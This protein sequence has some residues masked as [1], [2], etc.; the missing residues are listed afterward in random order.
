MKEEGY[1]PLLTKS[2]WLLLKRKEKLTESQ[3]IRLKDLVQYNLRS[4]RGYLLKEDFQQFW[5]YVS[6]AWAGKFLDK[7]IKKVMLS[8]IDPMKREARTIRKHRGLILNYFRAKK[9]YSSGIVE[10]LN[11]KVKLTTRKSYGFKTFKAIEIALYHNPG[12]LPE[13]PLMTHK[14]F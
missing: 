14:F 8:K 5:D 9:A 4:I 1:E 12:K 6:P 11:N 7:W 13:P 10:G 2:R 3:E